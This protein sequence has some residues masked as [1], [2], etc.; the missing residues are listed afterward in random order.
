MSGLAS[1]K[2]G[3]VVGFGEV[4][5]RLA[6][7]APAL[8]L[9]EMQLE[10]T[11]CGAEANAMVALTGFGHQVRLVTAL[12]DN[13][14]GA[15]AI[16]TL[17]SFAVDVAALR[18]TSSRLGLLFLQP[19]AMA[20]PSTITYDRANSAFVTV[21]P[22]NYDWP[23]L[24]AGADWLFIS[25]ITAALGDGPL[26]ALRAA[27]AAARALG[28]KIAFDTNFRPT[29]WQGREALAAEILDE[30]SCQSHL[31]FAGRRA[32]TMMTGDRF[33]HADPAEGFLAAA[34]AMFARAPNLAHVAATRR[35]VQTTDRQDIVGL[36]ADR[37][38][39]ASSPVVALE[40][41]VDRVGTGDAFAAGI[42]HGLITGMT[43]QETADFAT[44]CAQWAHSVPGDFLRASLGDIEAFMTGGGDV[45]R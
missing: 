7:R 18:P 37:A 23:A 39:V 31:L 35:M 8:L 25:G 43:R 26:A 28:V 11:F 38:G 21:D 14:L 5:L 19:G 15:A 45:R 9:Q 32:V 22:A 40:A 17:Q 27:I 36:L 16:R 2:P 4:L 20:R 42:V 1:A 6:S 33:E 29:L 10:A 13:Q 44:A 34:N 24:L 30:L 12:P 41:I 3:R